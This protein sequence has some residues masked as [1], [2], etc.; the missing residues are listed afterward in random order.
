M[1]PALLF[2]LVILLVSAVVLIERRLIYKPVRSTLQTPGHIDI[3]YEEVYFTASDNTRLHGWWLPAKQA[4]GAILYCHGNRGS[5][6]DRIWIARDLSS[7]PYH[8]FLFDYRG[9]GNSSGKPSARGTRRDVIAAWDYVQ[10]RLGGGANPPIAL[11]GSSLGGAIAGQL[12]GERPLRCVILE[13]TFTSTLSMGNRFYPWMF[14][15]LTC[16][17]RYDTLAALQKYT[18]PLLISHSTHDAV[19]PFDMG[20]KLFDA[21]PSAQKEFFEFTGPHGEFPWRGTPGYREAF[22]NFLDRSLPAADPA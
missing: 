1:F 15:R 11:F 9:Y 16:I 7:L 20:K 17:N 12:L 6:A 5:L 2:F 8:L 18:G 10:A 14:P 4:R 21:A 22:V 3:P 19:I 13:G